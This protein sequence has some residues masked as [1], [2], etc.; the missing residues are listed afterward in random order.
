[1]NEENA[2]LEERVKHEAGVEQK[3][4]Q[5]IRARTNYIL[6]ALILFV[7]GK[8][9]MPYEKR[10]LHGP[11]HEEF[12]ARQIAEKESHEYRNALDVLTEAPNNPS[13][14]RD[15]IRLLEKYGYAQEPVP[16]ERRSRKEERELFYSL[17]EIMNPNGPAVLATTRI[18]E[19][20]PDPIEL[21]KHAGPHYGR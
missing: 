8:A 21:F 5:Q 6:D 7:Y 17:H 16:Y 1:M 11:N 3:R 19:S 2:A 18:K 13:R 14:R 12:I 15:A 9:G 10:I 20:Y 4:E